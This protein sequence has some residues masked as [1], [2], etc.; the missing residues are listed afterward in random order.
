MRLVEQVAVACLAGLQRHEHMVVV[1][2]NRPRLL[3]HHAGRVVAGAIPVPLY[4]GCGGRR[5][6]LPAEQRRGALLPGGRPGTGG[7]AAPKSAGSAPQISNI[8]LTTRAACATTTGARPGLAGRP[9][10]IWQ[11]LCGKNP[12]GSKPRWPKAQPGDVA[13]MFFTS[14]TTAGNPRAWCT[15]TARCWTAPA[16]APRFDKLTS[17]EE[18]LAYLPP[19]WIG[20]NIFLLAQWLACGYVVNCPESAST[21]TIDLKALWAHLLLCAAAAFF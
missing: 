3:R 21:V 8:Y 12:S 10:R 1:G 18:V 9:D 16:R 13:A 19:A 2:A 15:P 6:H 14:G 11:G 4:Q 17:S 20:Q 7:Q 5:V